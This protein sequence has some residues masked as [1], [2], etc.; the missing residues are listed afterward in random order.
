MSMKEFYRDGLKHFTNAVNSPDLDCIENALRGYLDAGAGVRLRE[1]GSIA[2]HMSPT[3]AIGRVAS[4]FLGKDARAVRAILFDKTADCNWGL[5][6]HQDRTIVVKE[7]IDVAGF[8]PWTVKDGML[9]VAP[10]ISFL[11]SMVTLRL[12]IDA[13][14]ADNAPLLAAKGTHRMG[15]V[16]Y[17]S[18]PEI[19]SRSDVRCCLAERGDIWV[20]STPILH[21]SDRATNPRR[22]RVLQV[23]FAA[24]DLPE[25]LQWLGISK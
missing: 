9:H 6:W 20:Y 8:G 18:I 10:P 16:P 7:R 12:H 24:A 23:D 22:R 1:S 11:E 25:N 5:G 2:E 14:D 19:V 4:T 17:G 3:G 21:A 13:V 15:R